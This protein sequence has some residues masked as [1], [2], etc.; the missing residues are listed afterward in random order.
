LPNIC[1]LRLLIVVLRL[2]LLWSGVVRVTGRVGLRLL[3]RR[4]LLLLPVHTRISVRLLLLLRGR[5]GRLLWTSCT[6]TTTVVATALVVIRHGFL[7]SRWVVLNTCR[8]VLLRQT[9]VA[10]FFGRCPLAL[11]LSTND[12]TSHISD[13]PTQGGAVGIL[14]RCIQIPMGDNTRPHGGG[15]TSTLVMGPV[16]M[17]STSAKNRIRRVRVTQ[18]EQIAKITKS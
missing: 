11:H 10:V 5:I 1:V 9:A 18:K 16:G 15:R 4:L 14:V 3:L 8:A 6:S 17:S 7:S 12:G 2:L 13:K